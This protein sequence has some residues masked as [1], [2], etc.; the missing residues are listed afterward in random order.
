VHHHQHHLHEVHASVH[1]QTHTN[2]LTGEFEEFGSLQQHFE[3]S[4]FN[5]TQQQML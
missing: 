3:K 1:L 2:S 5:S 4:L